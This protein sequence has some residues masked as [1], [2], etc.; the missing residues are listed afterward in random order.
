ME[1]SCIKQPVPGHLLFEDEN[2]VFFR[3][4]TKY[5]PDLY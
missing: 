3:Q 1:N 4:K 2:E 5:D